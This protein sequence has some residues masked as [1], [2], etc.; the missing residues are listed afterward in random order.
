MVLTK[1]E[2]KMTE[3]ITER[4]ISLKE[5]ATHLGIS[6]TWLY[7]KGHAAGI[8]SVRIGTQYRYKISDLDVWMNSQKQSK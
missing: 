8:P 5:A 3:V 6:R 7:Q 1:R 2:E 4:W